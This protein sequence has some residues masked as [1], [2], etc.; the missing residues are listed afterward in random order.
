MPDNETLVE[1][2]FLLRMKEA[3][4]YYGT[5]LSELELPDDLLQKVT[6]DLAMQ[7]HILPIDDA[8]G[9]L[10][11]VTD[12]QQSFKQRT[13]IE[14]QLRRKV[15]LLLAAEENVRLALLKFYQIT[16]YQQIGTIQR[17]TVETDM[18]PLKGKLNTIL[19]TAAR[20]KASDI[21]IRPNS[22]NVAV[23]F[24]INGH[25]YDETQ[26][27]GIAATEAGN[28]TNLL[29]QMDNSGNMDIAKT[30]MPNEG[31]FFTTHGGQD[32]FVRMETLP[33]GNEGD[34]Q[35][36]NL[37]LLPQAG[38]NSQAKRLDDIGYTPED[39]AVIKNALYKNATG[40]F[41]N[42]GPTGAGK[43]T[44]LYAQIYYVLDTA[45][46]ELHVITIDDPIEIREERFTQVQV[47]KASNE[48]I[49]L[50]D[51]KILVAS[52]RA[53][54]DIILYNEIRDSQGATV[55]MQASTTGHKVFSTVHAS[56]CIRT[57]SRLLDLDVSRTT[58]LSELRLIIS[59]RLVARL[60][61]YCSRPHTLTQEE[62][63]V[64]S[65]D[66][67]AAL[68][69]VEIRERGDTEA[70]RL[71]PHCNHGIIGRTAIAE[72][73]VFNTQI[74]DALLHQKS[75]A[76][77]QDTLKRFHYRSMWEKGLEMVK[78]QEIEL[79]ELIR[80]VGKEDA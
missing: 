5:S 30:N 6:N 45:G 27:F 40:L 31:S 38:I 58:L 3:G 77:I 42:S 9:K 10:V 39:L 80:V 33:I 26:R 15:R 36:I 14:Q 69:A 63:A 64:L 20:E 52:L 78:R 73:V 57:I 37:R 17:H 51:N 28:V 76:D 46:E 72:Y 29:K 53:D 71:C 66:E 60:C 79:S 2:Y 67:L 21:H 12:T 48:A 49:S 61:P 32:I 13:Q 59:Q 75:F 19:Q 18:T 54:P 68:S 50:T 7:Y 47:R 16:N 22:T 74:R 25:I 23:F 44:S 65:K 8:D 11:L 35:Y 70:V 62:L 1:N 43:T 41:I 55:A 4:L 56:D 24:R 34:W